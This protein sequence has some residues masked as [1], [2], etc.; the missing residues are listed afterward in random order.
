MTGGPR[1]RLGESAERLAVNHLEGKGYRIVARNMRMSNTGEI[2]I[3][4]L[5]GETLVFCEVRARRGE[6]GLAAQSINPRKAARMLGHALDYVDDD[7][8][9]RRIDLVVV[10]LDSSG[11][12][13][14][15]EH[16]INAVT[17]D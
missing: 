14:G 6:A 17:D 8:E 3:V 13:I 10:D 16:I 1:R 2:D 12:L 9:A 4:A 7:H 15:L 5:D 11:K